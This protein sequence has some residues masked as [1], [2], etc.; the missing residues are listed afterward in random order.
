MDGVAVVV[1]PAPKVR[2]ATALMAAFLNML[3]ILNLLDVAAAGAF[4]ARSLGALVIL[5]LHPYA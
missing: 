2:A 5:T 1:T 3:A 4:K